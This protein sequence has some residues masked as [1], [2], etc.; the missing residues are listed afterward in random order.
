MCHYKA[1]HSDFEYHPRDEHLLD[2]I[3]IPEP[4]SLWEDRTHRLLGSREYGSS[5]TERNPEHNV[6]KVLT[7]P[8][9][10]TGT[11]DVSNLNE[12][13][14]A[15]AAYQKYLKD[16]L[17]TVKGIDD[18]VGRLLD[19]LDRNGM[20]ENTVVIY[21]SDQGML[22]G[23]HDYND[24]RWIFEESLQMPFLIRYPAE[25]PSGTRVHDLISNVDFAPTLL[26]YS[27]IKK[28]SGMQ[29]ISFREV[30]KGQTPQHWPNKIYYRY[31]LHMK[32]HD[33]PAHYGICTKEYKLIFF[34]GLPL[35]AVSNEF[36]P[37]PASWKLYDLEKDPKE[38][39]NVHLN[40]AYTPIILDLKT[41]LLN[42]KKELGDEDSNYPELLERLN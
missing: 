39:N 26:D 15:K 42:L 24:R 38:L 7:R 1:P 27:G 12:V 5:V 35:D 3:E 36:E 4:D 31:W 18:N 23:E 2:G 28:H 11:L 29:G 9:H 22:L 33:V 19:Y 16:Y 37:T 6:V 10:P 14:R 21:T 30:V 13:E 34:Y 32:T 25:I 40:A 41:Q 8:H 17:G 20:T